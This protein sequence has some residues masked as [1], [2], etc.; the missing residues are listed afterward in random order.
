MKYLFL[1]L[2]L[3]FFLVSCDHIKS[4]RTPAAP[5]RPELYIEEEGGMIKTLPNGSIVE[6]SVS[7][8][9]IQPDYIIDREHPDIQALIR[10]SETLKNDPSLDF[11][12]RVDAVTMLIAFDTLKEK[13]YDNQEYL[14]LLSR[15]K[16]SGK[17]I[18]LSEY[19]LCNVGVCREHA[20]LANIMLE[21]AG[22]ENH[23]INVKI[24]R[25]Q[26]R[27]TVV[28]DHAFNVVKFEGHLWGVDTY[29][30]GF[31][32]Y[33]LSELLDKEGIDEYS[34]RAPLSTNE[35]DEFRRIIEVRTYPRFWLPKPGACIQTIEKLFN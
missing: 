2:L 22:I 12:G 30:A 32:G 15:Y 5:N 13:E 18:P 11:W 31:N 26:G 33:L 20:L 4:Y 27:L 8:G 35:I 14:D 7:Q 6:G 17:D 34:P 19:V 28:E 10:M 3:I 1:S 23:Y 24:Q 16:N 25:G 9:G 29:Y 21:A